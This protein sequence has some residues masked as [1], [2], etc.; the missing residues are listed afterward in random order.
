LL[1][2]YQFGT[3]PIDE[4]NKRTKTLQ[5]EKESLEREVYSIMPETPVL[6]IDEAHKLSLKAIDIFVNGS[7]EQ[8]RRAV[9]SLI[10]KIVLYSDTIKIY[11]KFCA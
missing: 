9:S 7:P 1:D 2:L 6:S 8:K 4:I 10:N 5:G 3:I 11:W